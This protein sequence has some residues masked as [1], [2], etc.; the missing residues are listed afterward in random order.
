MSVLCF[1]KKAII[2]THCL[3]ESQH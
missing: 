2:L 1:T 3:C